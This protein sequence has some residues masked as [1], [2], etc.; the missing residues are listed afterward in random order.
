MK[1]LADNVCVKDDPLHS[2]CS[3]ILF[4]F[5]GFD[6][7]EL[8]AVSIYQC[9]YGSIWLYDC[10]KILFTSLLSSML[11]LFQ[12][13]V[14]VY[15]NHA[16]AGTS[17]QDIVHFAQMYDTKTCSRFDYG[18]A[19]SNL[20]HYGQLKPPMYDIRSVSTPVSLFSAGKDWLADPEVSS[21]STLM[22]DVTYGFFITEDSL[23]R[24]LFCN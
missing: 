9:G 2:L 1:W 3:N 22:S 12:T 10:I 13:R 20:F 16:P 5:C 21:I 24:E 14:P 18:S 23:D 19:L 11:N 6:P 4:L 8:N 7:K 17:V 15:I